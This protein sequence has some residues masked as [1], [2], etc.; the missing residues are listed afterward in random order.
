MKRFKTVFS[1]GNGAKKFANDYLATN[2]NK[3][4]GAVILDGSDTQTL[5]TLKKHGWDTNKIFIPN[6]SKDYDSIA[7]KHPNSYNITLLDFLREHEGRCFGMVYMDYM[8]TLDGNKDMDPKKD[9]RFLFNKKMLS[10]NAAL[11]ITISLRSS[12]PDVPFSSPDVVRCIALVQM[13][14]NRNGYDARLHPIGGNY[15]NGGSMATLLF[16]IG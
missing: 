15:S 1:R 7:R 13:L 11:G 12:Q 10:G 6:C 2:G 4:R 8:C 14:A 3:R 16:S 9:L 5:K